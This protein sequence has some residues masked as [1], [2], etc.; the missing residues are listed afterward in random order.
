MT[1]SVYEKVYCIPVY[2]GGENIY[3]NKAFGGKNFL[4]ALS[5]PTIVTIVIIAYTHD[6]YVIQVCARETEIDFGEMVD[7]CS[8][9][10][11]SSM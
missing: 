6:T 1:Y 8:R 2:F 5:M 11:Q 9:G 4:Q 10:Y 7:E 3:P